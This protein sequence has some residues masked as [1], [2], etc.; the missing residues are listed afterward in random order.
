MSFYFNQWDMDG[1]LF[2][3]EDNKDAAADFESGDSNDDNIIDPDSDLVD[4]FDNILG[5]LKPR[6]SK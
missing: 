4:E 3:D 6:V 5:I 2:A 1:E